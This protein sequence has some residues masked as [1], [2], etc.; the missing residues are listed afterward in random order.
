MSIKFSGTIGLLTSETSRFSRFWLH[1]QGLSL[2]PN[3]KLISKMSLNIAEARDEVIREAE[4]DWVWF[5]DDDH[6][7]KPDLLKNLL[8]REVDI[9]QPLVLGR[10]APFAPVMMGTETE[11]GSKQYR[12]ALTDGERGVKKVEAV[13]AAGM[14]IRRR[15]WEKIGL[16]WFTPLPGEPSIV[17]EDILFCRRARAKGFQI[18]ADLE[19]PMGHLNVGEVWPERD[20]DGVWRTRCRFGDGDFYARKAAPTG[21]V[22]PDKK[23][24]PLDEKD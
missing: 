3:I 5:M 8:S 6:T 18:Y 22:G 21:M 7:F 19:N 17:S 10:Y 4:G 23:W 15:V 24:I 9:I 13:G 12:L 16:R 2:P 1:F 14:L 11:D 20:A